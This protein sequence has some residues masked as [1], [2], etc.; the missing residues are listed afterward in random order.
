MAL[1]QQESQ[2]PYRTAFEAGSE[3]SQVAQQ[4]NDNGFLTSR[5]KKFQAVQ[6]QRLVSL[7]KVIT[8]KTLPIHLLSFGIL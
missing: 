7:S 5:D 1:I 2:S 4:L 3:L 8:K 6:V